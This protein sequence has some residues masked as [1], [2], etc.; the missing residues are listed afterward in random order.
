MATITHINITFQIV[1]VALTISE[2]VRSEDEQKSV[3][4]SDTEGEKIS[5]N[6]GEY[7]PTL[8]EEYNDKLKGYEEG[9]GYKLKPKSH[10]YHSV[11]DKVFRHHPMKKYLISRSSETPAHEIIKRPVVN[12][13]KKYKPRKMSAKVVQKG[14][15]QHIYLDIPDNEPMPSMPMKHNGFSGQGFGISNGNSNSNTAGSFNSNLNANIDPSLIQEFM[16]QQ[17][18]QNQHHHQQIQQQQFN[19][20]KNPNYHGM[21]SQH[22]VFKQPNIKQIKYINVR[23]PQSYK[24]FSSNFDQHTVPSSVFPQ[25]HGLGFTSSGFRTGKYQDFSPPKYTGL[26][27]FRT[28]Q[29]GL[30]GGK[31]DYFRPSPPL[32]STAFKAIPNPELTANH[33]GGFPGGVGSNLHDA[34]SIHG[35]QHPSIPGG[36]LGVGFGEQRENFGGDHGG[37]G[38][39]QDELGAG[40]GGNHQFG[41][42]AGLGESGFENNQQYGDNE[43]HSTSSQQ[44]KSEFGKEFSFPDYSSD[45]KEKYMYEVPTEYQSLLGQ[46]TQNVPQVKIANEIGQS[47]K[48]GKQLDFSNSIKSLSKFAEPNGKQ[49]GFIIHPKSATSFQFGSHTDFEPKAKNNFQYS[50][51]NSQF[52][53]GKNLDNKH[54]DFNIQRSEFLPKPQALTSP[55]SDISAASIPSGLQ[56]NFGQSAEFL[57]SPQ[58]LVSNPTEPTINFKQTPEFYM[59]LQNTRPQQFAAEHFEE[60]K[61]LPNFNTQASDLFS[62]AVSNFQFGNQPQQQQINSQQLENNSGYDTN[63]VNLVNNV[64][65]KGQGIPTSNGFR[66]VKSNEDNAVY[67][68]GKPGMSLESIPT[69]NGFIPSDFQLQNQNKSHQLEAN[70]DNSQI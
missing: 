9:F 4:F 51:S 12:L 40:F 16:Q 21:E 15:V 61:S 55:I 36:D 37:F 50:P 3:E 70:S 38:G 43:F 45:G 69:L 23:Q 66:M 17:Q 68:V 31:P 35:F 42:A 64:I 47:L 48:T 46:G 53:F 29:L 41:G 1:I 10:I 57:P 27:A 44:L 8:E 34:A 14:S 60:S 58:A 59:N 2:V 39:E 13:P 5:L 19:P 24:S 49:P 32:H 54:N 22:V 65:N 33:F 25:Q 28:P 11:Y 6:K 63:I 52:N 18:Q 30:H 26:G 67:L 7:F 62:K 20:E 56:H